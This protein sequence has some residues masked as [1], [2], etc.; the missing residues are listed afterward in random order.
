M[1]QE[2][3]FFLFWFLRTSVLPFNVKF[4]IGL[5][6]TLKLLLVLLFCLVFVFIFLFS[7][8]SRNLLK[9]CTPKWSL[10]I[11]NVHTYFHNTTTVLSLVQL[12]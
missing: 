6:F 5:D 2:Y 12:S 3:A 1:T 9:P 4:Y 10:K 7:T 8:V 11:S